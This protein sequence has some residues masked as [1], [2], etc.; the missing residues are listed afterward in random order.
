MLLTSGPFSSP[1]L[2]VLVFILLGWFAVFVWVFCFGFGPGAQGHLQL[3]S[4]LAPGPLASTF[5]VLK[6]QVCATN[7][8]LCTCQAAPWVST[9][10]W[11]GDWSPSYALGTAF[12]EQSV[13]I[14]TSGSADH[15]TNQPNTMV[16]RLPSARHCVKA[17]QIHST[18]ISGLGI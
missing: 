7:P 8:W 15:P 13:L 2:L 9:L 4:K 5:Q 1:L 14:C 18:K 11:D 3:T 16:A 10:A 17:T 6:L 12:G